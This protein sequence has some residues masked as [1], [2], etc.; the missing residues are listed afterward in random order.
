MDK[1]EV[2]VYLITGFLESGKTSFLQEIFESGEFADGDKGLFI[3]CEEG[4]VEIDEKVTLA[5]N[6]DTVTLEDEEELTAEFLENCRNVYRPKRV[7]VEYN[8]MWDPDTILNVDMPKGWDIYQIVTMVDAST[9]AVYLNNMKSII[10]NMIKCTEL[11]IF[12]RCSEEQDLPM[13]RRNVKALNSNIQMMFEHKDGRMIELGKDIPPYDLNADIIEIRDEDYGIWYMDAAD[14]RERYDGKTVRFTGRVMKNRKFPKGYMVPGRKAM[15][16]CADDIRFIGFLCKTAQI[17]DVRNGQW[18]MITA[19]IKY[20]KRR[21]YGG[22][23]PVL[24][25]TQLTPSEKPEE[26]LVYFN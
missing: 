18:V 2:P 26:E 25:A 14:D 6:I 12:N 23:G 19:K 20:E 10:G 4:E 22:I 21:E 3:S 5:C 16:C 24:Y 1:L 17:D 9:F 7:F 13:F 11:V 8:G 15:T